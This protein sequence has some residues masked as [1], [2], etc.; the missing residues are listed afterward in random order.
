KLK[1]ATRKHLAR[2]KAELLGELARFDLDANSPFT[3]RFG[4][5]HGLELDDAGPAAALIREVMSHP[6]GRVLAKAVLRIHDAQSLGQALAQLGPSLRELAI[7]T[8]AQIVN[9]DGL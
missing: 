3:W 9:L 2:Y 4:F 1:A 6:S 7:V 8:S 5:I